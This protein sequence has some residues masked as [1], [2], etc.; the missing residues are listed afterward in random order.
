MQLALNSASK[1]FLKGLS[2]LEVLRGTS[3]DN[4]DLPNLD[5]QALQA[6][7]NEWM[8]LKSNIAKEVFLRN[9]E[10]IHQ[11]EESTP[12]AFEMGMLVMLNAFPKSKPPHNQSRWHGPYVVAKALETSV[13]IRLNDGVYK[14]AAG[15]H[16][17]P[18]HVK[19]PF[20]LEVL[21]DITTFQRG[22]ICDVLLSRD[23]GASCVL[24]RVRAASGALY[25][26]IA[27]SMGNRFNADR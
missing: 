11:R 19:I 9:A 1:E 6:A 10:L 15:H 22:T 23:M 13:V 17:K 16:L 2:P 4:K 27:G 8:E 7:W 5:D 3:L 20:N 12:S 14:K 26:T 21:P 24:H 18:L 25:R